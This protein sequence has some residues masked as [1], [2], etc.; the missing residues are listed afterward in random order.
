MFVDG[1]ERESMGIVTFRRSCNSRSA[2]GL[3][4]LVLELATAFIKIEGEDAR[5]DVVSSVEELSK[6]N[7][8]LALLW[9][10]RLGDIC[11]EHVAVRTLSGWRSC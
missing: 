9:H 5:A 10:F 8:A 7:G 11:K 6:S 2:T 3:A 1:D 4:Q